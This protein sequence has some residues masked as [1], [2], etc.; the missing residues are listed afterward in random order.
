M[1][2]KK[3]LSKKKREAR[4]KKHQR[5]IAP[6]RRAR[7]MTPKVLEAIIYVDPEVAKKYRGIFIKY[8]GRK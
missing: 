2:K 6:K 3:I 5:K 1:A 8:V 4:W 7:K